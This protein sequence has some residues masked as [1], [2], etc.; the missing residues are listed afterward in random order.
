MKYY[1]SSITITITYYYLLEV[2]QTLLKSKHFYDE[3]NDDSTNEIVGSI[4][5]NPIQFISQTISLLDITLPNAE[6]TFQN[7]SVSWS[8]DQEDFFHFYYKFCHNTFFPGSGMNIFRLTQLQVTQQ[9]SKDLSMI[10]VGLVQI[11]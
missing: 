11:L 5:K 6:A 8:E 7:S 9:I 4:V 2:L 10:E 3:D 1:T